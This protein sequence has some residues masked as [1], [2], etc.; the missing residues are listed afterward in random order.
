MGLPA[1][2][3]NDDGNNS[4]PGRIKSAVSKGWAMLLARI[5]ECLPLMCRRCGKPMKIIAF[6]LDPPVIERI[7]KHLGE[8]IGTCQ[9]F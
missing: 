9:R 7:L 6:I 2:D 1:A 3:G 5:Y 4:S 8:P